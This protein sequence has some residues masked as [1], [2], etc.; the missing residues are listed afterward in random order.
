MAQIR[1]LIV[2]DSPSARSVLRSMLESD[3]RIAVVGEAANGEQ[4]VDLGKALRPD[5]ITMDINMPGM[6][7]IEAIS[8]IMSSNAVPILV[9]SGQ[10]DAQISYEAISFGAL[11]VMAKPDYSE[12]PALISKIKMLAGVPVM[13]HRRRKS[14]I[15]APVTPVMQPVAE[16][17]RLLFAIASSTGGPQALATI[18]GS[19]PAEFPSPIVIAQHISAGFAPGLVQ[20]LDDNCRLPVCLARDGDVIRPGVIYVS[21]SERNLTV[22]QRG[23]LEL[24]DHDAKQI[25]HPS[26]DRLLSSVAEFYG[27]R[28]V[29]IVLTGMGRDGKAGIGRIAHRGGMTVAQDEA[30]SIIYG[31]NKEAIE[32]GHIQKIIPLSELALTMCELAAVSAK[33]PA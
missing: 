14:K 29:G 1:V 30:S 7:G 6:G 11:D 23:T 20:W 21:P 17:H 8:E 19:L 24:N 27:N 25:Y 22:T 28:A 9:V 2:D 16:S 12:G 5:V 15:A 10:C 18:L 32:A 26:C 31:M 33:A 4:A 13:T 3:K